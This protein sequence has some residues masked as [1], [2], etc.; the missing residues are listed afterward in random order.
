MCT[1]EPTK[2]IMLEYTTHN[3]HDVC[4]VLYNLSVSQ[5]SEEEEEEVEESD[6]DLMAR[7]QAAM[8]VR[9]PNPSPP[10]TPTPSPPPTPPKRVVVSHKP[11]EKLV[12]PKA[13]PKPP[14]P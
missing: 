14:T 12:A 13:T 11:I 4:T 3:I 9:T 7:L 10:P 1:V 2:F 6:S 8:E 5:E